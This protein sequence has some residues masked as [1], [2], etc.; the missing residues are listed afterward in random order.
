MA[1][2]Y[3]RAVEVRKKMNEKIAKLGLVSHE[4][5]SRIQCECRTASPEDQG[6]REGSTHISYYLYRFDWSRPI[7]TSEVAESS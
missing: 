3:K 1:Q 5:G 6:V 4:A 2:D 7:K